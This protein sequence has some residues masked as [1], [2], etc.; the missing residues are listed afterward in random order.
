[1]K[2]LITGYKGF[3]GQN[4]V[5]YFSQHDITTYEYGEGLRRTSIDSYDWVLH[6]GAISSTTE[7][8]VEKIMKQN[9]DFTCNLIDDCVKY[10][11]NLQFSSSA[12]VYGLKQEFNEA[13]AV[14][15]RTPYA[16]SKYMAEKYAMKKLNRSSLIQ[17]FRYFNVH[18]P[19]E[20]HKG[21]QASPYCQFERQAKENG[22]I[23]VF[24]NSDKYHRDFI[25]V[26]EVLDVQNKFLNVN[27]SGI[28]N[29]GTGTTKSF[30]DVAKSVAQ[31]YNVPIEEIPMP[32]NLKHSY[33]T[34]TCADTTKL[35]AA[36]Q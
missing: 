32:E 25:H 6:F 34:Y 9:Y 12:S 24:E 11:V 2:I 20:E 15:P 30:L 16:W 4:A 26:N 18:G 33:Q 7:T 13:S 29:L 8:N 3:I 19:H 23:K 1:M 10:R 22:V 17:V 36:L 14:D 27:Q 28:W 35:K 21:N 31:K 5:K